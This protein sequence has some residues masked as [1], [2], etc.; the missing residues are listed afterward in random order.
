MSNTTTKTRKAAKTQP[1]AAAT[2]AGAKA[3]AK[4]AQPK[5]EA[6]KVKKSDLPEDQRDW[7]YL[8]EKDPTALHEDMAAWIEE[9]TGIEADLKTV[10]AVCVLRMV[11]QRSDRNKKR[12]DYRPLDETI[13]EQRRVHME[14]AHQDARKLREEAKALEEKAKATKSPAARRKAS[15]QAQTKRAQ[16]DKVE[17]AATTKRAAKKTA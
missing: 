5:A 10:Q 6:P 7:T 8:A 13:V 12:A 2:K 4:K 11:Y 9:V 17:K 15:T 3:V 1:K 14:Q 16:A